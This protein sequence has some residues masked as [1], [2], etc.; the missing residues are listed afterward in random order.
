[1][2]FEQAINFRVM[3]SVLEKED[4]RSY[5]YQILQGLDY[6]HS[7][8]IIHRDIKPGNILFDHDERTL[9]IADWGL[10]DFYVP[11]T[12]YNV[13]VASRYFKAP[14]LLCENGYYDYQLDIWSVGCMLAGMVF[15]R[16]PFF[17][18]ADNKD[19][20]IKIAKVTGTQE[21]LDY[22]KKY[23]LKIDWDY[24]SDKLMK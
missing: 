23:D 7:K 4:I 9:K 14:E 2:K 6:A 10:A 22:I 20:L 8:G 5:I 13:R 15:Q 11:G 12:K 21:I 17:K 1:M 24:Y 3:Y 16:E 18:G 19:Q